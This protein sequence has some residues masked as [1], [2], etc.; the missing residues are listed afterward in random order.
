[1]VIYFDKHILKVRTDIELTKLLW[2]NGF[3]VEIFRFHKNIN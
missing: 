2:I 1:M 3:I